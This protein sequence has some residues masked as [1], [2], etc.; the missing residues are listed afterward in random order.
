M[1]ADDLQLL[2]ADEDVPAEV[3]TDLRWSDVDWD[4]A[5][6][7]LRGPC[8]TRCALGVFLGI[9]GSSRDQCTPLSPS[10][11]RALASFRERCIAQR[12]R[13]GRSWNDADPVFSH[14]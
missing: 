7:R 2:L 12:M 1:H 3:M 11:I 6:L 5:R 9:P 10:S 14:T 13:S 4:G 8:A